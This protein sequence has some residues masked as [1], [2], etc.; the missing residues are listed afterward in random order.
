MPFVF[1]R[2]WNSSCIQDTGDFHFAISLCKE[3]KYLSHHSGGFFINN[4]MPFLV[5][6]FLI[7]IQGK[8]TD[9]LAILSLVIKYAF[10]VFGKVFQIP[11]IDKSVNLPCFFISFNLCVRMVYDTY[12]ANSPLREK[13]V[14]IL[15]Y[16]L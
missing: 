11:F 5:W 8:C 7:P 6:V 15:F 3:V 4:Q 13:S 14:Y 12:K 2:I 9:M 1:G 16:K 10:N